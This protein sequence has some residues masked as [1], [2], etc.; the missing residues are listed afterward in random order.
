MFDGGKL[1]PNVRSAVSYP[2]LRRNSLTA[3]RLMVRIA[4][5]IKG[6]EDMY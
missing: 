6:K 1:N 4:E 3:L 2:T 5:S